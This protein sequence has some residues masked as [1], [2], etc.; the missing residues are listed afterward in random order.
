MNDNLIVLTDANCVEL[1]YV[2]QPQLSCS[3]LHNKVIDLNLH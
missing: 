3:W 2:N 1:S